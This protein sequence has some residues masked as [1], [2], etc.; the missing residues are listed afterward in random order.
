M[1]DEL[2]SKGVA[3]RF[4]NPYGAHRAGSESQ[5]QEANRAR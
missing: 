4:T 2:E 3:I 5:S 1:M